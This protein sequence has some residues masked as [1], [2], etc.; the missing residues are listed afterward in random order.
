M[1]IREGK[2]KC[3]YC[4]ATNRGRDL[5]CT[6]CGAAR[7]KDVSFFLDDDAA[8]VTDEAVVA[9]ARGGA[10]WICET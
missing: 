2:W 7:E 5:E 9:H 1:A 3:T 10:E 4:G 6:A 8:E